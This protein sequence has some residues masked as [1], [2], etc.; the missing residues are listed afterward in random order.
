[1]TTQID[2]MALTAF[3]YVTLFWSVAF[4]F[5]GR[6]TRR[7]P[8]PLIF[9]AAMIPMPVAVEVAVETVL[10]HGSAEVAYWMFR[11]TGMTMYRDELV[12]HLQES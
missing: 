9:L 5:L 7:L 11:A 3:A 12:F 6:E 2:I 10:R 8:F 1:M 4:T